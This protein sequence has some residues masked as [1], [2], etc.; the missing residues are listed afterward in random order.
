MQSEGMFLAQKAEGILQNDRDT[1]LF[2]VPENLVISRRNCVKP[3][4]N[5]VIF[6][7][8]CVILR[9]NCDIKAVRL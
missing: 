8:F 1:R 2:F 4:G 5:V 9:G 3:R 6:R 7:G